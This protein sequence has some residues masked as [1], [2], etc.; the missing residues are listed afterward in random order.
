MCYYIRQ[1]QG[2]YFM[3]PFSINIF[4]SQIGRLPSSDVQELVEQHLDDLQKIS[5][6]DVNQIFNF[7]ENKVKIIDNWQN[8]NGMVDVITFKMI[9]TKTPELSVYTFEEIYNINRLNP[10]IQVELAYILKEDEKL[11]LLNNFGDKLSPTVIQNFILALSLEN[12]KRMIV[13]FKDRIIDCDSKLLLSFIGTLQPENQKYFL[14]TVSDFIKKLDADSISTII[15]SVYEENLDYFFNEYHDTIESFNHQDFV[16]FL[17]MLSGDGIVLCNKY[18]DSKIKDIPADILMYKLGMNVDDSE[19]IYNIWKVNSSKLIELSDTYFN[20]II[21]RL[22]DNLR[23]KSLS[24][25][26]VRYNSMNAELLLDMFAFDSNEMKTKLFLEYKNKLSEIDGKTFI[27]Y[28][29]ENIDNSTLKNK[30]FLLYKDYLCNLSD[31]EFI[32]FISN[33]SERNL[34]YSWSIKEK[35]TTKDELVEYIFVNFSERLKRITSQYIPKL[36]GNSDS[37]LQ[38]KYIEVLSESIKQL[39]HE[40]TYIKDLLRLVWGDSKNEILTTFF[41]DFKAL[42]ASDWYGLL[43]VIHRSEYNIIEKLL[44]ECDIDNFDFIDKDLLLNDSNVK[45]MFYYFEKNIQNKKLTKYTELAQNNKHEELMAEYEQLVAKIIDE[46]AENVLIDYNCI[47]LLVLLR[48]LLKY[49]IINDKDDY[50]QM[51]KEMYMSKL[52]DSLEKENSQNINLIKDSLFYRLVKGSIDSTMLISIKTL[53]GLIFFNKNNV[54]VNN[55][56]NINVYTPAEIESF[57]ENLTEEQIIALN[58]KLFKQIC[59]KL[60]NN[61]KDEN[62]EKSSIRNLAIRLYLAVGYQNAKNLIDLKVPF[63]RYEYI[64][65]GIDIKRINLNDNGEPI[66]NK[67]L[68]DFMF[69]SNISDNTTNINRLLQDKIPEFEKKFADVYNGWETIYQNLNGNVSVARI[70]KWFE[71]NKIL[72][73]PDEYRLASVLSEIGSNEENLEK[74]RRL[75]SDMKSRG[76]STIPKVSGSYND[77][78][79]YEMLDLD[80]PLGLVVG[81]ITRC[82]FLIDGVSNTSLFHSAQSKD[83][84]IFIVR[85]NGE[86]VAQSWVWRNGNLV[87]FDNVETRGTYDYDILLE[88]Y[89]KASQNIINISAKEE[90]T[91]EQIKLVTFGGRYSKISKPKSQVPSDK[92]QTPRVDGHIYCDAEYE[93]FILASNGERELYYGDVKIQYKDARKKPDR[94]VE[95]SLLNREQKS[96]IIKKIRSIEFAKTGN[97]EVFDF[98]N[99]KY[100]SIADDWY[101]LI[102]NNGEVECRLLEND[103]RAREELYDELDK[104]D[105]IFT[106]MG[107]SVDPKS[108]SK[109]VLSLVRGS[110]H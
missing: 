19:Q 91:K 41:D 33:Y 4:L 45:R 89:T 87:C 84:R 22:D 67:K 48:V 36:F 53:K 56:S 21:S 88:T 70:L 108:V 23:L 101:M 110:D 43:N 80:D 35:E 3:K 16:N 92:I 74:A 97:I 107:V 18:F 25:F 57:V 24:D 30:I 15:T 60:L 106:E 12:Q 39:I 64:F 38:H 109:K 73:N 62:P 50:Y 75:Y 98:D 47:N 71:E 51:F 65:N 10:T 5:I 61:Y 46:E 86:L 90:N 99:Y 78:Y 32:Y 83:G 2:G 79:T 7:I 1:F 72:L 6:V 58:N 105:K 81:Y 102:N 82:C 69:G 17:T 28:V 34:K 66:I 55:N 44:L 27:D 52:L 104:L 11:N 103:T 40:K 29:N 77:E 100:G 54:G 20:L 85:K 95:L 37:C 31:E 13:K 26:K 68:N 42:S 76:F 8:S 14:T 93:Q 49:H 63:T 9:A 96:S 59:E 94:Y